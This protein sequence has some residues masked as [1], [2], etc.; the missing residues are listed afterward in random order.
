MQNTP[1]YAKL[2]ALATLAVAIVG[3]G[4]APSGGTTTLQ[5]E[6]FEATLDLP[7]AAG[8]PF[9]PA[10]ADVVGEFV[11]P[12]GQTYR[13]PGFVTRDYARELVAGSEKLTPQGDL[14]WKLRFT[15]TEA[16]DWRWRWSMTT[17]EGTETSDW[18][19]FTVAGQAGGGHGFLRLSPDDDRYLRFDDG[20]AYFAVGENLAWYDRRGTF[21]Y[22]AWFARLAEQGVN[23]VRL[24]MP[25]WAFGLEWIE[26]SAGGEVGSSTLGNY[27][28]RLDR[29]WQLDYVLELAK[30]HGIY[31][32]LS[33][34]NHGGFSLRVNSEWQ[35][36]PY[37]AANGG[38]LASPREFFT[39][40]EAR[41]LFKRR[42]RYIVARWGYSPNIL[43]WELWNEVDL[44]EQPA[45]DALLDWHREMARELRHLDPYDH[46]IST[47]IGGDW[48][49][50]V[51]SGRDLRA[52]DSPFFRL[53]ELPEIDFAQVH[54]YSAGGAPLNFSDSL[55]QI[56]ANLRR[57][58]KP[59]L[60][61]EAGVDFRG[62]SETIAAD[63]EGD[64]FHDILWSGFFAEAFGTGMSWWWDNVID[65]QD[66]Y[67]HFGAVAA[68]VSGVAFDREGFRSG[69]A[70]ARAPGR[71]LR[72]FSLVGETTA[73][74]W[75][76][77]AGHQWFSPDR[78]KVTDATLSLVDLPAGAWRARWMDTR[79]GKVLAD[80]KVDAT[81]EAIELPVPAFARDVALR[82]ERIR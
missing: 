32:M 70:A 34:Q 15:P 51:L 31:V 82:L 47:S 57:F 6:R 8:N 35:D 49:L 23:Y 36:N 63:P 58:A 68:F 25:S 20:T 71:D 48:A 13:T 67:F 21:A 66:W 64:G 55:P 60:V 28:E 76:K 12:S 5:W 43:A 74:V 50:A 37:N 77:N 78:S 30:R 79:S 40:D 80:A 81:G 42:L 26:R 22:D 16:G 29:A 17:P 2:A 65:P 7:V 4:G 11:S 46:L 54:I 75:V 9:D 24:W 59:V 61:A 44:A 52:V 45:A 62:P 73:L 69:S 14:R 1:R 39:N 53:W 19:R 38:P 3:C 41:E 18:Q 72:A 10:Q 56:A 33:L 27:E